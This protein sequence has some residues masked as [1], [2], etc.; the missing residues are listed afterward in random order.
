MV[1]TLGWWGKTGGH[2]LLEVRTPLVP[3]VIS[4]GGKESWSSGSVCSFDLQ[5]ELLGQRKQNSAITPT[6]VA[7]KDL[8]KIKAKPGQLAPSW[9]LAGGLTQR[10][11]TQA[12][13]GL[14]GSVSEVRKEAGGCGTRMVLA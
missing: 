14:P 9:D 7:T 1:G 13:S 3:L 2:N 11:S 12:H 4:P 8:Q 6:G 5:G 10:S